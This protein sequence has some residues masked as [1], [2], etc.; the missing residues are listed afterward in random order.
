MGHLMLKGEFMLDPMCALAGVLRLLQAPSSSS[1]SSSSAPPATMT[2]AAEAVITALDDAVQ[3]MV[4]N[5]RYVELKFVLL[6]RITCKLGLGLTSEA[7][8]DALHILN[9]LVSV[10]VCVRVYN[11]F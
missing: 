2:A 5:R 10:C 9:Y 1:S 11:C 4:E 7:L 3:V 6:A 8:S